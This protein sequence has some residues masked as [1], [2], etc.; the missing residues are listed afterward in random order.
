MARR[1]AP[2]ITEDE[3]IRLFYWVDANK[4]K[5]PKWTPDRCLREVRVTGMRVVE[6]TLKRTL[7]QFN[8]K[9]ARRARSRKESLEERIQ[10]LEIELAKLNGGKG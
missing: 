2:R 3:Q 5:I 7:K 1:Y 9:T 8:L 6:S 10:R 4:E